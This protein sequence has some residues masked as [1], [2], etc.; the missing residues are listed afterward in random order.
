M[1][2]WISPQLGD[3]ENF[4]TKV[5]TRKYPSF[6][7]HG[8]IPVWLVTFL[9]EEQLFMMASFTN[10]LSWPGN[11]QPIKERKWVSPR[12]DEIETTLYKQHVKNTLELTDTVVS[13]LCISSTL[14]QIDL[15][16]WQ[17]WSSGRKPMCFTTFKIRS[18]C[19]VS[20]LFEPSL[21]F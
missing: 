7:N 2:I 8:G 11:G 14:R 9:H 18:V 10:A 6:Q 16:R 12:K 3:L 20:V 17:S 4:L 21:L 19:S 5:C 1:T 13:G 15:E